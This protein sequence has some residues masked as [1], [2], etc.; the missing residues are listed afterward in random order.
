MKITLFHRAEAKPYSPPCDVADTPVLD[1][2]GNPAGFIGAARGEHK[3]GAVLHY[4]VVEPDEVDVKL[5]AWGLQ[6]VPPE[7]IGGNDA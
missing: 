3:P 6:R 2:D 1:L 5:A 4:A 7:P